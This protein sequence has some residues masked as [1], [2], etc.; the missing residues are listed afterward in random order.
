[1]GERRRRLRPEQRR[2]LILEAGARVFAERG[3]ERASMAEIAQGAGIAKSVVYDHFQSKQA[4]HIA[5]LEAHTDA[6]LEHTVRPAAEGADADARTADLLREGIEAMFGFIENNRFAWRMH[7]RDP[8][9]EPEIAE[10]HDRLH[11]RVRDA[12]VA[13]VAEAPDLRLS[14]G[15]ARGDAD[16]LIAE[17]IMS[18]NDALATWW[19]DHPEA[20][21]EQL[22]GMAMDVLL[23]GIERIVGHRLEADDR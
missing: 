20:T 22:V 10:V 12:L 23:P 19:W 11:G 8:P 15:V 16:E 6:L 7:F 5:L 3:Y 9:A 13:V 1:M 14:V 2:A 21:R 17:I 18:V 4:L